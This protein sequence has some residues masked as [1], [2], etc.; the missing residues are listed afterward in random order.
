MPSTLASALFQEPALLAPL[1][2]YQR[3]QKQDKADCE[4]NHPGN[5]NIGKPNVHESSHCKYDTSSR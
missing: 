3:K 2:K 4:A 5:E 1:A